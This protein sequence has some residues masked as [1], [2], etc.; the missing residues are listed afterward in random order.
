M[1]QYIFQI[2]D[3]AISRRLRTDP[4]AAEGDILS[5][6]DTALKITFQAPTLAE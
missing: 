5:G 2:V 6:Q 3:R 1:M 4:A